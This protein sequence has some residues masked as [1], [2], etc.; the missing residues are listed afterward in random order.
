MKT[1][2][3]IPKISPSFAFQSRA[4]SS[5]VRKHSDRQGALIHGSKNHQF[6]ISNGP[7]LTNDHQEDFTCIPSGFKLMTD[8]FVQH[9]SS[10]P[11]FCDRWNGVLTPQSA[12]RSSLTR[13]IQYHRYYHMAYYI[14]NN[15]RSSPTPK[16]F[17]NTT[18]NVDLK[19]L[20][21]RLRCIS[22]TCALFSHNVAPTVS[23][24]FPAF[25]RHDWLQIPGFKF[26]INPV[27]R[28]CLGLS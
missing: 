15:P 7:R 26:S 28:A 16:S 5:Q 1:L 19:Y 22:K 17:L 27:W 24:H 20:V 11:I 9:F 10:G 12:S 3:G 2:E 13:G 14:S 23:Q 18:S 8:R 6:A 21:L 4:G 25:S